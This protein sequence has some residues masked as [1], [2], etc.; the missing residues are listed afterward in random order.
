MEIGLSGLGISS[1]GHMPGYWGDE[2]GTFGTVLINAL[3]RAKMEVVSLVPTEKFKNKL[4]V[5]HAGKEKSTI[6]TMRSSAKKV[7]DNFLKMR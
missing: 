4:T 3:D 2:L 5:K 1:I 6:L 7:V